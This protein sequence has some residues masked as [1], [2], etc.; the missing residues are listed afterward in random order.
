MRHALLLTTLIV[1]SLAY[2]CVGLGTTKEDGDQVNDD[3]NITGISMPPCIGDVEIVRKT[4]RELIS[5]EGDAVTHIETNIYKF[6][7]NGDILEAA[8]YDDE[9]FLSSKCCYTYYPKDNRI[10][11]T[12]YNEEGL[13][14]RRKLCQ[15]DT[16][17]NIVEQIVY[18]SEG[19]PFCKY[20][21][22]YNS[23]GNVEQK[24][25]CDGDTESEKSMY[26]YKYDSQ[27]NIV[28]MAEYD[29]HGQLQADLYKF[30]SHGNMIEACL[31]D[32]DNQL[33]M[34]I[35]YNH[36]LK[37]N[38]INEVVYMQDGSMLLKRF[39]EY[40][41]R[42][43]IADKVCNYGKVMQSYSIEDA[44]SSLYYRRF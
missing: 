28:E 29:N 31:L 19:S 10:E 44:K 37:G 26:T 43:D 25:R 17:G 13:L 9:G 3:K 40:Y 36:D 32:A 15:C 11:K 33:I 35:V 12:D 6:N 23:M 8:I 20:R 22:L 27:G 38:V 18:N 14:R 5:Y 39:Y 21:Y 34:R 2:S 7:P 1:V 41:S 4:I 24:T 16:L 30:D 42:C